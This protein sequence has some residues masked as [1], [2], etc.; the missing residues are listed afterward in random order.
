MHIVSAFQISRE[1]I[2]FSRAQLV[3]RMVPG[4]SQGFLSHPLPPM[5]K[6]TLECQNERHHF[7]LPTHTPL[8]VSVRFCPAFTRTF[9]TFCLEGF[10]I[11]S[12]CSNRNKLLIHFCAFLCSPGWPQTWHPPASTSGVL[13]YVYHRHCTVTCTFKK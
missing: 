12:Q 10:G 9:G 13:D 11:G 1:C 4:K 7:A 5:L 6:S 8:G 3:S 2:K